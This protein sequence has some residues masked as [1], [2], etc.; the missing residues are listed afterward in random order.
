MKRTVTTTGAALLL[1]LVL[2]SSAQAFSITGFSGSSRLPDGSLE[3]AAGGHP[4]LTTTIHF[5]TEPLPGGKVQPAGNVKDVDVQLPPGFVGYSNAIPTCPAALLSTP[6][7]GEVKCSP[8]SQAGIVTI[9]TYYGGQAFPTTLPLYNM[10]PPTGVATQFGFNVANVLVYVDSGAVDN[11]EYRVETKITNISQGLPLGDTELTLWGVPADPSHNPQRYSR[12]AGSTGAESNAPVKPLLR[13]PTSCSNALSATTVASDSWQAPGLFLRAGFEND[14]EGNPIVYGGCAAVPFAGEITAQPTSHEADSP[15]GFDVTVT[16]PQNSNPS[17]RGTSDLRD[18]A[19]TLPEGMAINASSAGGLTSCTAAQVGLGSNVPAACPESSK[20]GSVEI[21]TP[22]LDHPVAGSVYLAKQGENKFGALLA[23]YIAVDDPASGTVLKLPGRIATNPVSGRIVASF[24]ENPQ[25]PFETLSVKFFGGP[26]A[27]L[28]TPPACGTYT[29]SAVLTPWS[30]NAPV[31]ANDSFAVT[32]GPGG[33]ACPA[34]GAFGPSLETAVGSPLAGSYSP[35]RVRISRADGSGRLGALAVRLPAGM[36]ARL[37]G[38]PYCPDAALA[39]VPTAEGTGAAQLATPSCP[40]ASR[41][42]SV[43]VGAGAGTDPFYVNTGSAYLAGPYKGAPLS[44]AIVTPAVAGPFDLGNVVVR[45]ALRVNPETAR[46]TAV[47]DALPTILDGV[48]LDLRD[49]RV[50]L[51]REDFTVQPT[52]CESEPFGG[53]ATSTTG[54]TAPLRSPYAAIGCAGLPF[55]PDLSLAVKGASKR[56]GYPALVAKLKARKGDADIGAVTV[57]LPHSEFLAQNHIGTICTRPQFAARK[58]PKRSIYGY[59]EARTPLLA[60]PLKGPVYLR[61]NGGA[62]ELPD[63]VAAL[64]GQI[65]I[66]LVGYIDSHKGGIRTRFVKV[67]DAPISSFTLRMKGG[68][69]SLLEN[70]TDLCAAAQH[71]EVRMTGQNG[72]RHDSTP[73]VTPSCGSGGR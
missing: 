67:P 32:S 47:T 63:L 69:K 16:I 51:D 26:R 46:V 1:A 73:P 41:V 6:P 13:N 34:A 3:L 31:M 28:T 11:G 24:D 65:E 36:L 59:A 19:V 57:A 30:G 62:R 54:L 50:D 44:L 18:A 49:V 17:G 61:A 40:A 38:V 7:S 2:A 5:A 55:A 45:T 39:A 12:G 9:T 43:S 4:D 22:L 72:K 23:A 20:I 64:R 58:C 70:S 21:T 29:T 15:S 37:A 56:S 27:P 60:K 52:S 53:S 66:D 33:G 10:E 48:P 71:A 35:L 68:E 14:S 25:L 42:G 8:D